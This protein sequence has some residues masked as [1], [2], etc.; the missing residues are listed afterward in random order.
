MKP[1]SPRELVVR[2]QA[3]EVANRERLIAIATADR[4]MRILLGVFFC[5]IAFVYGGRELVDILTA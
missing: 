4:R 3:I 1:F 2:V 5:I